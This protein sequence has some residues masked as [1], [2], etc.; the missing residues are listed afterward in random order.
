MAKIL[1]CP[2]L[3]QTNETNGFGEPFQGWWWR[4]KSFLL[5][6][7]LLECYE[8][9]EFAWAGG[10]GVC[11]Q[12]LKVA[13]MALI[14]FS[15]SFQDLN[16]NSLPA[17]TGFFGCHDKENVW[18][19]LKLSSLFAATAKIVTTR[20]R[21]AE[22]LTVSWWKLL[23]TKVSATDDCFR[24]CAIWCSD[25]K[26]FFG[27]SWTTRKQISRGVFFANGFSIYLCVG[28]H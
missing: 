4:F 10:V 3:P 12:V 21:D 15:G 5:G 7:A 6:I 25:V 8:H 14:S 20:E 16:L 11:L 17:L 24:Q 27:G 18:S 13:E 2:H 22:A 23:L 28:R 9:E 1:R 26:W 19:N